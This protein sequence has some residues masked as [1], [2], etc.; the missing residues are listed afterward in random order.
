VD[1]KVDAHIP[2]EYITEPMARL[3]VYRR[4][5]E[6][7]TDEA[8]RDVLDELLDRFGEPPQPVLNL[9][10]VAQLKAAAVR[11]QI[12]LV[13]LKGTQLHLKFVPDAA[14]DPGKLLAYVNGH[15]RDMQLVAAK[16]PSLLVRHIPGRWKEIFDLARTL[17]DEISLCVS[18]G[19]VVHGIPN[20]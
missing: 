16:A 2:D 8:R 10:D 1:V 18:A 12:E 3:E 6:I 17:L 20:A 13:Q 11:A 5:A 19:D 14:L 9:M 15:S 7:D 4:I